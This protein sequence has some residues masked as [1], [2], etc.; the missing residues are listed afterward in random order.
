MPPSSTSRRPRNRRSTPVSLRTA[1]RALASLS[2][3]GFGPLLA[4]VTPLLAIPA[5]VAAAGAAGWTSVAVGQAV[6][7]LAAIVISMSWP[8]TGPAAV[9]AAGP[10]DRSTLYHRSLLPQLLAFGVLAPLAA[11]GAALVAREYVIAGALTAVA[12]AAQG[13]S[14]SWFFIGTNTP[15]TTVRNEAASRFSC[16]VAAV[17]LLF[18]G[19]PLI[20][21]PGMLV[22]AGAGAF[23]LNV[24][25]VR[26]RH[27][28]A[29][30]PGVS[31]ALREVRRQRAGTVAR[32]VNSVYWT[33]GVAVVA[34]VAPGA[35]AVFAAADRVQKSALN[36]LLTLP[37]ALI[38]WLASNAGP[39][40]A[41]RR[42]R[43][44]LAADLIFGLLAGTALWM[45]WPL[46]TD[47]LFRGTIGG[48][49]DLRLLSAAIVA[50]TLLERSVVMHWLVPMQLE[51][52][53]YRLGN[54]ASI[55][56]LILLAVVVSRGS[57]SDGLLVLLATEA[58]LAVI[59]I[60]VGAR[61]LLRHR[62]QPLPTGLPS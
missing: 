57:A 5:I 16:T 15:W 60:A 45:V 22:L 2:G 21:Y 12:F 53:Y 43:Q 7:A 44:A 47:L 51:R 10:A 38:A 20:T 29:A 11:V 55:G 42:Y 18:A 59:F 25:T 24:Q 26:R 1:R 14:A 40:E 36:A 54:V 37:Q 35:A 19:A 58:G 39:Q 34:A 3:Y 32:L 13:L 9:A 46:A 27:G 28:A 56:A 48:V 4:L 62:P 52:L 17:L 31:E 23:W 6:G 30:V 8:L 61:H 33:G 50:C 49:E 41:A